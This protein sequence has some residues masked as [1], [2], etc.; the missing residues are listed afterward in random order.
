MAKA[1]STSSAIAYYIK[2]IIPFDYYEYPVN[3]DAIIFYIN[4]FLPPLIFTG[5]EL[6]IAPNIIQHIHDKI[7]QWKEQNG[8]YRAQNQ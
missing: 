8:L 4:C 2:T 6:H 3:S 5:L 1:L 7:D